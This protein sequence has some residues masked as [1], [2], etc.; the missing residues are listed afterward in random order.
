MKLFNSKNKFLNLFDTAIIIAILLTVTVMAFF[1]LR[2]SKYLTVV[3]KVT[4]QN[5]LYA[6]D[7]PPSWFVYYFREGMVA[8]DGLGRN[9]AEITEIYRYDTGP[10]NKAL[11]LT[12]E[13]KAD[14]S[15]GSGKYSYEGKPLIIGAPIKIEFQ[16]ILAEGLVTYIEGLP[17]VTK[18]REMLVETRII[19]QNEVFPETS[20]VPVYMAEAIGVGEQTKDSLGNVLITIVNKRVEPAEKIVTDDQG[21]LF[22]NRDPLKKDV[23]LTLK[24]RVKEVES[25]SNYNEY[26][27]FD[28]VRVK[29]DSS[30]PIHLENI[31]IYPRVTKILEVR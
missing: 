20:G 25:E 29:I 17:D 2:R 8:K 12:L 10:N 16:D 11:Y 1:F 5:V 19:W 26:Y 18:T 23:F 15:K 7:S 3:V 22:V 14:Y 13:L 30:I 21:N 31:S 4:G 24:L 6:W 27:L 28:D 9:S